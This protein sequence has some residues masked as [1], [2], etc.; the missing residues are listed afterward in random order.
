MA[1]PP[2]NGVPPNPPAHVSRVP[3][4]LP[5]P[6]SGNEAE[7]FN[8][9]C[10]R[11]EV[12]MAAS[13]D[14]DL[15]RRLPTRLNGAAFTFWDG[16]NTP[17]QEDYEQTKNLLKVV[18]NRRHAI[19]AFQSN[20]A[21]RI[22]RPLEPLA[23][24]TADLRR[25]VQ[26]AYP[27]YNDDC[28]EDEVFRR[29]LAGLEVSLKAKIVEHGA[30]DIKK[31]MEISQRVEE[32]ASISAPISIVAAVR[33]PEP[34]SKSP[35]LA[36]EVLHSILDEVRNLGAAVSKLSLEVSALSNQRN[37]GGNQRF[38][39]SPS[40]SPYRRN[41]NQQQHNSRGYNPSSR[42]PS[43][44]YRDHQHKGWN[45]SRSRQHARSPSPRPPSPHSRAPS[46]RTRRVA[47]NV[48]GNY[49]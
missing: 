33:Q 10:R 28:R 38:S 17:I 35:N 16:L 7:D 15:A 18:F 5:V 34:Q 13:N 20:M 24:Y 8:Q 32:A 9:W 14:T 3:V 44:H 42:S 11:F 6:F 1:D 31:A 2:D 47:F 48:P 4:E 36:Q 46:P 25:L 40:P 41:F 26:E 49:N 43:P 22:R 37:H 27:A 21:A 45:G 23:V 19:Q 12:A 29:F 39:R 30:T